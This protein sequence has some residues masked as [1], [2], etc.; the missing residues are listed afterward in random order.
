MYVF[1]RLYTAG[2]MEKIIIIIVAVTALIL[3]F[4]FIIILYALAYQKALALT[5][6]AWAPWCV[7]P[8]DKKWYRN[9]VI[10]EAIVAKLESLNMKYP[11]LTVNPKMVYFK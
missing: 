6:T 10:A 7:V 9:L 5:S 3:F 1:Y 8:A 4:G 11:K 2:Q